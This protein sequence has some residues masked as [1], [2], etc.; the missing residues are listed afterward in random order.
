MSN[1]DE[2]ENNQSGFGNFITPKQLAKML[3]VTEAA[4]T[5]K[6]H[7]GTGFEHETEEEGRS[8]YYYYPLRLRAKPRDQLKRQRSKGA[9]KSSSR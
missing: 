6:R 5:M 3:G 8:V 9:K 4:L 7:H 1:G 2:A